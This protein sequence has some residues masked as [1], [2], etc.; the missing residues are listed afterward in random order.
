MHAIAL[1]AR[2]AR[3]ALPVRRTRLCPACAAAVQGPVQVP[4]QKRLL[5]A[6]VEALFGFQPFFALAA[7][8]V[9][10]SCFAKAAAAWKTAPSCFLC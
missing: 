9:T 1:Q 8:Q 5:F 4:V 6:A 2:S 10:L 7:K 3:H